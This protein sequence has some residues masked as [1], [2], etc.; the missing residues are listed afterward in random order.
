MADIDVTGVIEAIKDK[1][2]GFGL[3]THDERHFVETRS[4]RQTWEVCMH[5]A[6]GCANSIDLTMSLEIEPRTMISF[7]DEVASLSKGNKPPDDYLLALVFTW[8]SPP[9]SDRPDMLGLHND[10]AHYRHDGILLEISTTSTYEGLF[11][12]PQHTVV[13]TKRSSISLAAIYTG[14]GIS[15][16]EAQIEEVS[17][18]SEQINQQIVPL[19]Y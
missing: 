8:M 13:F 3:H 19:L 2:F 18:I 1:A 9:L 15:G 14:K 6:S 11:S 16:V 17:R 10:F 5:H 4:M 12:E 7:A